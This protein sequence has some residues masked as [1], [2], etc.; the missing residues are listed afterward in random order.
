MSALV[1]AQCA[2]I[3]A[4]V[5]RQFGRE[6][7]IEGTAREALRRRRSR[8]LPMTTGRSAMATESDAIERRGTLHCERRGCDETE[9]VRLS[10]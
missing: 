9:D 3:S 2:E 1:E 4:G 7:S 5:D 10:Q 8:A 6:I